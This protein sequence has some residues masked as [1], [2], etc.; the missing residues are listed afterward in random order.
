MNE[1]WLM[2]LLV[3]LGSAFAWAFFLYLARMAIWSFR[4]KLDV[5]RYGLIT[6]CLAIEVGNTFELWEAALMGAVS[7]VAYRA[8]RRERVRYEA[9]MKELAVHAQRLSS[10]RNVNHHFGP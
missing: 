4:P 2:L 8:I 1:Y 5:W 10:G 3:S 6:V 9:A 7:L